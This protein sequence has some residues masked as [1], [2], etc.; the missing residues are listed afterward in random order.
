LKLKGKVKFV[1]KDKTNF[2]EVLKERV[3]EY[4]AANSIS[5]YANSVMVLKTISMMLIYFAPFAAI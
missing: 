4:F 1:S 3:D 2:F 5:K